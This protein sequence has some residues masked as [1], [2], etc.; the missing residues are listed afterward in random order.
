M[1]FMRPPAMGGLIAFDQVA[2]AINVVVRELKGGRQPEH[3][4][5][6]SRGIR[7]I[8][9]VVQVR[10]LR[11]QRMPE[12]AAAEASFGKMAIK[13]I[14]IRALHIDPQ[15]AFAA[16]QI[17]AGQAHGGTIG[18]TLV[19]DC[20]RPALASNPL[21]EPLELREADGCLQVR[22]LEVPAERWMR[23]VAA[24]AALRPALILDLTQAGS[25]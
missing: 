15:R 12:P 1:V 24:G 21:V 4:R 16:G 8:S 5:T 25:Q 10:R 23:I 3:A 14:P 13:A 19:V 2:C 9:R 17:E 7:Q 20:I 6:Q 18:Q 11:V 22:E